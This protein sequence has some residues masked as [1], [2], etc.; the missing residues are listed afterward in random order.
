MRVSKAE[1][2]RSVVLTNRSLQLAAADLAN[3]D[4]HLRQ[5]HSAY[6]PPPM[7]RRAT[8][9]ST[10]V[11]I[12]LEQQVSLRSAAAVFDRLNNGI[13]PFEPEQLI[14]RGELQLRSIGLTRQKAAY[15]IQLASAIAEG[16]LR[17]DRLAR[18]N[19]AA[20]RDSLMRIKGIGA[21]SADVYLLMAMRRSDIWPAGDLALAVAVKELRRL[22]QRPSPDQLEKLA[23]SWRPY[24]AVA[25]RMLWQYYLA[26]KA[27]PQKD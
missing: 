13:Q 4:S 3:Y 7:W 27:R 1:Q 14:K 12:I 9:F 10:L 22:D 5:I 21:W 17:L 8:G 20:A 19:D 15:V 16:E 23:E 11:K 25:A 24:R 2:T 26:R 6:G 18:L